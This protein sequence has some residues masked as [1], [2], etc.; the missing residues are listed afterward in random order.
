MGKITFINAGAGSGKTHTLT[1]KLTKFIQS[2]TDKEIARKVLLT[3]FTKKAATEIRERVQGSLLA[4]GLLE[5]AI[6]VKQAKMSTVHA[7]CYEFIKKYWYALGIPPVFQEITES[8]KGQI[9][10][11]VLATKISEEKIN[12][13]NQFMSFFKFT[14]FD[15]ESGFSNID[16]QKWQSHVLDILALTDSNQISLDNPIHLQKSIERI[17]KFF[18]G[19][20]VIDD[21]RISAYYSEVKEI[22]SQSN[23]TLKSYTDLADKTLKLVLTASTAFDH[24]L[25]VFES[26]QKIKKKELKNNDFNETK[27]ALP[28]INLCHSKEIQERLIA[29]TS[30]IF[31]LAQHISIDYKDYKKKNGIVDFNDMERYFLDLLEDNNVQE[32]IR[33]N[34]KLIMVD[35]FQDSNPIQLAIFT[36]L[37]ELVEYN[38]WVGD[39]KQSIYGFRGSDPVL[40][41]HVVRHFTDN[42]DSNYSIETLKMSW[43]STPELV[44][45]SNRIF[46][47]SLNDQLYPFSIQ[48]ADAILGLE[49]DEEF[50]RWKSSINSFPYQLP[51]EETIQLFPARPNNDMHNAA[52]KIQFWDFIKEGSRNGFIS[53]Q[54]NEELYQEIAERI[55]EIVANTDFTIYDKESNKPR[56]IQASDICILTFSN[57]NVAKITEILRK[58]GLE[59]NAE[60]GGLEK[61]AEYRLLYQIITLLVDPSNA[62]AKSEIHYLTG[63]NSSIESIIEDRLRLLLDEEKTDEDWSTWL[64]DSN[65]VSCVLNIRKQSKHLSVYATLQKIV[66]QFNVFGY[67]KGFDR[68]TIRM[69]NVSKLLQFAKDYESYCERNGM[70]C[71]F[72]G[73]FNYIQNLSVK[74]RKQAKSNS[75]EAIHVMT[76]H[77][78]KGL[79]WPVTML[80]QLDKDFSS[81]LYLNSF[82]SSAYTL[83]DFD[84]ANPLKN[85]SL[86]FNVWPEN[87]S[88]PEEI[89]QQLEQDEYFHVFKKRQL[90]EA[91][92]LLYV[93]ITRARDFLIF[94]NQKNNK[95]LPFLEGAVGAQWSFPDALTR[96]NISGPTTINTD[97]F[98]IGMLVQYEREVL[99][100]SKELNVQ[101]Q[102]LPQD[103]FK[104][105]EPLPQ[106]KPFLVNPS[107]VVPP[108]KVTVLQPIQLHERLPFSARQISGTDELGNALHRALYVSRSNHFYSAVQSMKALQKLSIDLNIFQSNTKKFWE[109]LH[110]TYSPEKTFNELYLTGYF[111]HEYIKGEADL[112]LEKENELVL[113]DYKSFPG[114]SSDLTDSSSNFYAGKYLGQL[115]TYKRML[116]KRFDKPVKTMLIYYLVQGVIVEIN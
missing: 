92:R 73:F 91:K 33:D 68:F 72:Q 57:S 99:S 38:Y 43:R 9:L 93:G 59:V 34:L 107:K 81:K 21:R 80:A 88:L 56:R 17:T 104:K 101:L 26:V 51:I 31:D 46:S 54:K 85:R 76:Y 39:P 3:T 30:L 2:S 45:F 97:L 110:L 1:H 75:P 105:E 63:E 28:S 29:Y 14:S 94:I 10:A 12:D 102:H 27:D 66:S 61:T 113:I 77:A 70:A 32:D 62:L 55:H 13:I 98:N 16:E 22:I 114:K 106:N 6:L 71:G 74:E 69:E 41:D 64:N 5:E 18:P 65:A 42:Q 109:Y 53:V 48:S 96:N 79:E 8:E 116:E 100:E 36:K 87:I 20:L 37:A 19:E 67:L 58:N 47:Q 95:N 44:Q 15:E 52:P 49:K 11:Q 23:C 84:L 89:E 82:G 24:F 35:E 25:K 103:Y 7:V 78:S 108:S 90:N 86:L 115:N 83:G 4:E 111:G 112:V 40:I 60:T 50:N